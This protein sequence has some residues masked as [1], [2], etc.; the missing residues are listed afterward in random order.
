MNHLKMVAA[1]LT[2]AL[3]GGIAPGVFAQ[4][5]PAGKNSA[6]KQAAVIHVDITPGHETNS[7]APDR[8]MGAGIDRL[9]YGATRC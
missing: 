4:A 7:F 3:L 6:A 2:A 8:A 1:A 9:R 5:E